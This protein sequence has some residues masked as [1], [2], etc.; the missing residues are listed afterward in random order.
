MNSSQLIHEAREGLMK[1]RGR[2][3]VLAADVIVEALLETVKDVA[4][5]ADLHEARL[6]STV[7]ES[8]ALIQAITFKVHHHDPPGSNSPLR[9]EPPNEG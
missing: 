1:R 7:I 2:E 5:A 6:A 3:Y 9:N 4:K 8:L